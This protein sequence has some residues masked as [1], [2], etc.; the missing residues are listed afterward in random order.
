MDPNY[1]GD[2]QAFCRDYGA[3]NYAPDLVSPRLIPQ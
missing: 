2:E 1:N 3:G